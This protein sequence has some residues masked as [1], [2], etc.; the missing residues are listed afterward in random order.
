MAAI[1]FHAPIDSLIER[2]HIHHTYRALWMDWMTQGTRITRNICHHNRVE[3]LFM[4]VNHGPCL[5]DRNVFLSPV[6][7]TN[8]S[9]GNAYVHNLF[10]GAIRP[11]SVMNRETPF[12]P[13]HSTEVAALASI[14]GGADRFFHNLVCAPD[15][16]SAMEALNRGVHGERTEGQ[17]VRPSLLKGNEVIPLSGW[18]LCSAGRWILQ[19]GEGLLDGLP[20]VDAVTSDTL[21]LSEPSGLPFES[22]EGEP[23]ILDCDIQGVRYREKT[24]VAGPFA[25][26][27]GEAI[28]LD[29]ACGPES[30]RTAARPS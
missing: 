30:E 22:A 8:W 9:E 25:R 24:R 28:E 1:K 16:L 3:D 12:H 18:T 4:E 20:A 15:T 11:M 14:R 27:A 21:E 2:N 13:A 10:A 29:A 23:L 19:G 5:V 26:R 6:S 17:E 7:L